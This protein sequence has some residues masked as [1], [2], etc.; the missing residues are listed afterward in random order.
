M[1]ELSCFSPMRCHTMPSLQ[2]TVQCIARCLNSRTCT[3]K[4]FREIVRPGGVLALCVRYFGRLARTLKAS[5]SP[6]KSMSVRH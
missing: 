2:Q 1:S 6:W 5:P 4:R 3:V